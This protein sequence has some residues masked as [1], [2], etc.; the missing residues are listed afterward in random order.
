MKAWWSEIVKNFDDLDVMYCL[1]GESNIW[2]EEENMTSEEA[3]NNPQFLDAIT[4]QTG[5]SE[6]TRRLLW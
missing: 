4:V 6:A 1:T 2:I 5:H 3:V